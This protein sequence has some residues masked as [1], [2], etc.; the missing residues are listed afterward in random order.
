[1]CVQ[2]AG[3]GWR[4]ESTQKSWAFLIKGTY[5]VTCISPATPALG[6]LARQ[7]D[8][9]SFNERVSTGLVPQMTHGK[10]RLSQASWSSWGHP[11]RVC[12]DVDSR[13]HPPAFEL[14][15]PADLHGCQVVGLM[16]S[17]QVAVVLALSLL[18]HGHGDPRGLTWMAFPAWSCCS[19]CQS[20]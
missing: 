13:L 15:S 11:Q 20:P 6:R 19:V 1:M 17:H 4:G 3:W 18:Q 2:G 8:Q 14:L 10:P 16:P 5:I 12:C 9:K 7:E